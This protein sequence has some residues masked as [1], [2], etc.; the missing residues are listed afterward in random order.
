[1]SGKTLLFSGT[2]HSSA[3]SQLKVVGSNLVSISVD[4]TIKFSS[5]SDRVFGE[6]IPLG[7]QPNGVD[8]LENIVV[9][10]AHDSLVV[11]DGKDVTHKLP[12]KFEPIC[13]AL[14]PNK[15]EVAVGSKS[16]L[17]IHVYS[18][19]S[20]KL[21]EKYLIED[22]RGNV[23]ALAYSSCGRYLAAGDTNREV[24][25]F[26]HQKCIVSGWVHHTSKIMT[27]A[28]SP[29]SN[30]VASGSVDSSVIVWYV[31]D[32][33]K[34]IQLKLAHPGGVRGVLFSDNNTIISVGEDCS[35]KAWSLS[36]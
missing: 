12:V 28:W 35:M 1:M 9:V 16:D 7:S 8:G 3:V 33:N 10:S 22:H 5:L 26:E 36:Y 19:E 4:D 11:F 23:S 32:N 24:K 6:G 29:D 27:V 18:L 20:G 31:H 30:F 25:I 13:I 34:R 21:S 17:F 15:N 2:P 14:S